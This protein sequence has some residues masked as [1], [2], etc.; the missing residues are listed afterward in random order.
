MQSDL[1]FLP[2]RVR[3]VNAEKKVGMALS[4]TFGT[5]GEDGQRFVHDNL[6]PKVSNPR[7]VCR[8]RW[9]Q[10]PVGGFH[11]NLSNDDGSYQF[12]GKQSEVSAD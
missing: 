9:N 5:C 11:L 12:S 7:I 3:G 1:G 10:T 8:R 2:A 6:Y 4:T